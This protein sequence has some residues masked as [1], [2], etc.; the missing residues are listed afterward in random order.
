MLPPRAIGSPA[1]TYWSG[2]TSHFREVAIHS[3]ELVGVA[4][5]R[6]HA[7]AFAG[8]LVA[9]YAHFAVEGC[10]HGVADV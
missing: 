7:I 10:A 3:F 4:Y 2:S 1:F 5:D 6:I 8:A 9:Y